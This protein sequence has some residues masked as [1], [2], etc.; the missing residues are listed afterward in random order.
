[1]ILDLPCAPGQQVEAQNLLSDTNG[2]KLTLVA[3]KF[4]HSSP[5]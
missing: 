1:M 4:F 5:R 2:E 3:P